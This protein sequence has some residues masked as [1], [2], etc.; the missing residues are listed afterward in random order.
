MANQRKNYQKRICPGLMRT[1]RR[2]EQLKREQCREKER[3]LS[4]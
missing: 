3:S 1:E 2:R 4:Y